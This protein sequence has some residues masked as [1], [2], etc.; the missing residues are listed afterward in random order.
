MNTTKTT[1]TNKTNETI[2]FVSNGVKQYDTQR[3]I[4]LTIKTSKTKTKDIVFKTSKRCRKYLRLYG[5]SVK[6]CRKDAN[7]LN[8]WHYDNGIFPTTKISKLVVDV[9]D[10]DNQ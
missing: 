7:D 2:L 1:K 3:P 6:M 8:H 9:D 5:L 4:V 10:N